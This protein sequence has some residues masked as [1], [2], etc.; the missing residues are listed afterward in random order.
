[1]NNADGT[2]ERFLWNQES[3][4]DLIE[5]YKKYPVLY[6]PNHDNYTDKTK[7]LEALKA[8]RR[9]MIRHGRKITVEDIR[10]KI[11]VLRTQY[12]RQLSKIKKSQL[13]RSK[14]G[15]VYKPR[16]WC[17]AQLEF[18]SNSDAASSVDCDSQ[19]DQDSESSH[20]EHGKETQEIHKEIG[21][22]NRKESTSTR[23]SPEPSGF[24]PG[25]RNERVEDDLSTFGRL[26][27]FELRKISSQ[28]SLRK[29]K[30]EIINTLMDAQ[31]I[32]DD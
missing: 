17:F 12:A 5:S 2:D 16:F 22:V 8:I 32:C 1:M 26:V 14:R 10:K 9:E 7:R 11:R 15:N 25:G 19:A 30:K 24:V 6:A 29:A 28:Q 4:R 23:V 21:L 13:G 20:E 27:E 31:E 3:T 18:L